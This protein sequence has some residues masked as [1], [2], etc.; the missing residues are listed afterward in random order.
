MYKEKYIVVFLL[1]AF[2]ITDCKKYPEG[3]KHCG[4]ATRINGNWTIEQLLINGIDSTDYYWGMTQCLFA[5]SKKIQFNG[6]S[7][8]SKHGTFTGNCTGGD[9][10]L[11]NQKNVIVFSDPRTSGI[12]HPY[13]FLYPL[14]T[15]SSKSGEWLIL[16][17]TKSEMHLQANYNS[18]EYNYFFKK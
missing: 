6:G 3:G 18:I 9:W 12:G 5:D 2:C 15:A 11:K 10:E 8:F 7:L 4:V 17:L 16:K 14:Y 13:G 1:L